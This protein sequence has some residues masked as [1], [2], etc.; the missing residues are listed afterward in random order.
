MLELNAKIMEMFEKYCKDNNITGKQKEEKF[1]QFLEILEKSAYDPLEAIGI[2]A[3]HSI[4]EPAT[5][6]TMR[7]YTMAT[8][9]DRLSKVT[10]GLPR[11]IEIFDAK[12]SLE[13]QMRIYLKPEFN[14]KEKVRD[15]AD[16]IKAKKIKD[17]IESD[18][19]DLIDLK[20][21]LDLERDDEK[22]NIIELIKKA[23]IEVSSRG[24][25]ISI[26][27]KKS[28]VKTLRKLR[29]KLLDA[30]VDGIKGIDEV[31]VVKDGEDWMIQTAGTNLKKILKMPEIDIKRTKTNDVFQVYEVLGIEAARAVIFNEAKATLDEQG[32]DVDPRHLA[33]LADVMTVDGE[34]KAIG[35][36]GVSG[37]K[38]SVLA[39]ANF[40]ET[41]KHL[42]NASFNGEKD[43]LSGVIENV[44][45]VQVV[46]VGTGGVELKV[47]VDKMM[48]KKSKKEE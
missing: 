26:K 22:D 3:A 21:E 24:K 4:S 38:S 29:S 12:K 33:L 46:P 31:I 1:K 44:L 41:K 5:Q 42:V 15:I 7:T 14:T 34:V 45:V 25:K 11:L 43:S 19:I 20:I 27:P 40:E 28:D 8:Q 36:Y 35:R 30:H 2:I 48:G 47:D 9:R 16:K 17:V 37:A 23:N 10:Q 18:S 39:R 6:M 13:K 32:L